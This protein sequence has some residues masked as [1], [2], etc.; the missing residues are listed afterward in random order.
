MIETLTRNLFLKLKLLKN[1]YHNN[2]HVDNSN[3]SLLGYNCL[4]DNAILLDLI[5]TNCPRI[6]SKNTVHKLDEWNTTLL[7]YACK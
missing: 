3:E 2:M 1:R 6:W 5:K 4:D 7:N